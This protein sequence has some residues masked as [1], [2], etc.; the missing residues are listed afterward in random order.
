[1]T[2]IMA[3]SWRVLDESMAATHRH[4]GQGPVLRDGFVMGSA[5]WRVRGR[6]GHAK[7]GCNLLLHSP[8]DLPSGQEGLVGTQ[9]LGQHAGAVVGWQ[10]DQGVEQ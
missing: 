8:G 5:Y 10:A 9:H 6:K 1:M 3:T 2:V 4:A 7:Q